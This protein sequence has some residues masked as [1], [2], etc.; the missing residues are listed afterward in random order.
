MKRQLDNTEI[1]NLI[2]KFNPND[3]I[4]TEEDY[5]QVMSAPD[6]YIR[7]QML[8]KMFES[9]HKKEIYFFILSHYEKEDDPWNKRYMLQYFSHF[10]KKQKYQKQALNH[11]T[12]ALDDKIPIVK[13]EAVQILNDKA[14]YIIGTN[15]EMKILRKL[16]EIAKYVEEDELTRGFALSAIKSFTKLQGKTFISLNHFENHLLK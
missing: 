12:I 1:Q 11:I 9:S 3:F 7:R 15:N 14:K 6:A 13:G 4:Q 16:L 2:K 8:D 10:L 5:N